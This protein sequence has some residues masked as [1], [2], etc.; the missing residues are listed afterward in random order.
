MNREALFLA[1]IKLEN[2]ERITRTYTK[3]HEIELPGSLMEDEKVFLENGTHHR[4]IDFRTL[5]ESRLDRSKVRLKTDKLTSR[6]ST[7]TGKIDFKRI[8]TVA[9]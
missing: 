9:S 6:K 1:Y 7:V 3:A 4:L 2:G 8:S 5:N